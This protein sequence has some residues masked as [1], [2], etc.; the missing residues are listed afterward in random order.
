VSEQPQQPQ[1]PQWRRVTS[2]AEREC[3]TCSQAHLH[4][5]SAG[6]GHLLCRHEVVLRDFLRLNVAAGVARDQHCGGRLWR[7]RGGREQRLGPG[8]IVPAR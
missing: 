4:V 6:I 7:A 1:R 5:S 8:R 2:L 3:E